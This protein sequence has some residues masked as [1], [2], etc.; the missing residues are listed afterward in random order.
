VES[1]YVYLPASPS[2][3]PR[4]NLLVR[5]PTEFASLASSV[6]TVGHGIDP[7]VVVR[8]T[9][10]SDNLGFWQTLSKMTAGLAGSL[11]LFALTL[12]SL[13]VYGVVSYL[14]SRRRREVGIR[15]ALGANARDVRRLIVGQT[16]TPVA[17]G[18]AIGVGLA[19][20]ASRI[21]QAVLFGVSP[22]DPV[23][24]VGAPLI[25]LGVAYVAALLPTRRALRVDPLTTLRYE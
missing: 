25:L 10:L 22:L 21:L 19:A 16:L 15:M 18:M 11:S 9:R 7:A 6:R 20:L 13:G 24:F 14:V 5:S 17:V 8:V 1:N 12:A 23:A 4:L 3:Q 2:G